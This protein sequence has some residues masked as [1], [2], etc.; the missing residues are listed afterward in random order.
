MN[1]KEFAQ[2][3]VEMLEAKLATYRTMILWA[4]RTIRD[5]VGVAPSWLCD[6]AIA[7]DQ[8]SIISA[9]RTF[10]YSEPF[11]AIPFAVEQYRVACLFLR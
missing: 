8:P 7:K 11:E 9:V 5:C 4:D 10:A 2:R 3:L 1:E 6:I